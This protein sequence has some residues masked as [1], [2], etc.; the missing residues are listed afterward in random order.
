MESG[1][2]T[3]K[4]AYNVHDIHTF[5][6]QSTVNMQPCVRSA[7]RTCKFACDL[8][9]VYAN[10]HAI[11]ITNLHVTQTCE[12][13]NDAF[14]FC[15]LC[16]NE[17]GVAWNMHG[18]F[19]NICVVEFSQQCCSHH[20]CISFPVLFLIFRLMSAWWPSIVHHDDR[21]CTAF[22]SGDESSRRK[23]E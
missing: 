18:G 9:G 8:Y 14:A 17:Y 6:V 20:L 12:L 4:L 23:F 7:C 10:L 5:C 1:C 13:C 2:K 22:R 15:G 19:R 16:V 3:C 11:C 21:C